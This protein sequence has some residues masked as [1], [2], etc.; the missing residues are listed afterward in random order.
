MEFAT[1]REG[2]ATGGRRLARVLTWEDGLA[3]FVGATLGPGLLVVALPAAR[4]FGPAAPLG[5]LAALPLAAATAI[6]FA[7]YLSGPLA[8]RPGG[9]YN[10]VSR[11]WGSP[12]AGFVVAWLAWGSYLGIVAALSTWVG[13]ALAAVGPLGALPPSAWAVAFLTALAAVQVAGTDLFGWS[14]TAAVV[15]LLGLLAVVL[16]A[17]ALMVEPVN[18][19]PLFPAGLYGSSFGG[20]LLAGFS[21][22]LVAYVGLDA[23]AQTAGETRRARKV[24]PRVVLAGVPLVL[25]VHAA[26]AGVILGVI[27]WWQLVE[28]SRRPL[29]DAA[30]IFLPARATWLVAVVGVLAAA[31]TANALLLAASRLLV[32]FGRDRLV[33][34]FAAGVRGDSRTPAA[35][36]L[37]CYALAVALVATGTADLAAT[38]AP[39]GFAVLY[40]AHSLSAAALPVVNPDL[41]ERCARRFSPPTLAAAGL[42][43][44]AAVGVVAWQVADPGS[45]AAALRGFEEASVGDALAASPLLALVGW[46]LLGTLLAV[47]YR[48]Y[49]AYRGVEVDDERMLAEDGQQDR[50]GRSNDR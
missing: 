38:V 46:G 26:V 25:A 7:V 28:V 9:A 36:L 19:R 2:M 40:V 12:L 49:L 3:T 21:T 34:G 14:Q 1:S 13:T 35:S 48:A 42:T 8:D 29:T 37:A 10:H 22:F 16:V 43:S 6:P 27:P 11:T 20:R 45:A 32:G 47:R 33:P 4:V 15:L 18:F 23:L 17:G 31:T 24:L 39:A 44:A 41:Y 5:F 30:A 50:Y